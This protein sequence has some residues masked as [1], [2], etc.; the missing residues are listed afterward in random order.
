MS[1]GKNLPA[2]MPKVD[3]LAKNWFIIKT[4]FLRVPQGPL[5]TWQLNME[6]VVFLNEIVLCLYNSTV[7][8]LVFL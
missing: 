3:L 8:L 4:R 6:G 7:F 1:R 5:S 2:P